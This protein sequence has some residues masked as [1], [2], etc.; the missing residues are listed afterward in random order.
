MWEANKWSLPPVGDGVK[1]KVQVYFDSSVSTKNGSKEGQQ[2]KTEPTIND[3]KT[4]FQ[5]VQEHFHN[6]SVMTQFEVKNA[7]KNEGIGV[8]YGSHSLNA[9]AT[10][11]NLKKYA[12]R[13]T[14]TN[15][16]ITYFFTQ[17]PLLQQTSQGDKVDVLYDDLSTF[18]TFCSGETSAAVVAYYPEGK[19]RHYGAAEATARVFG[20]KKYLKFTWNDLKTLLMVFSKCPKSDCWKKC[21]LG[22]E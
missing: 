7:Q 22:N 11:E 5:L 8:T 19:Q 10:L 2:N 21:L 9:S 1:V 12:E 18:K 4:L 15:D 6:Q 14:S 17:K 3:F 20:L 13:N 16:T